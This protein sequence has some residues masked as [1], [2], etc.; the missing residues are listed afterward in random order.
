V[1]DLNERNAEKAKTVQELSGKIDQIVKRSKKTPP[2]NNNTVAKASLNPMQLLDKADRFITEKLINVRKL[3]DYAAKATSKGLQHSNT[4]LRN[5]TGILQNIV[6]GLAYSH[7]DLRNKLEFTGNRNYANIYAKGLANDLYDI[8]DSDPVSLARVHSVLD[9]EV[10]EHPVSYDELNEQ[11]KNL[12]DMIRATNDMVHTWHYSEGLISKETFEKHKG[13][14]VARLYEEIETMPPDVKAEF[15]KSRA[16]FNMFKQRKNPSEVDLQI[17]RDP[18]Y[19]TAKRVAQMMQNQ[20]IFEYADGLNDS[21]TVTVSDTAFPNSTQLGK[22]GDKPYYG[23]LTGKFVPNYVAQDFKGF[24]YANKYLNDLYSAFKGYDKN[25][26]RQMLKKSKTVYSP[27]VQLGN[28]LSNYSFAYW[29]GID[30]L[31]YSKNLVKARKEVKNTDGRY[32]LDL[33]ES[34]ILGTDLTVGDL[35]PVLQQGNPNQVLG[36][37]Q[38]KIKSIVGSTK[39][40]KVAEKFDEFASNLYSKTDD[41]A[42]MSAYISLR[43]DYGYSK[44]DAV[45]RIYEGFQNYATVGKAYDLA[46]R[47]PIIGNPYI[48]FKGDLMRILKNAVTRRPLTSITYLMTLRLVADLLSEASGEDEE[49]KKARERRPFIPKIKVPGFDPIPLVWQVPGIGEV[50]V[51]RFISPYSIYSKG[52]KSDILN[53]VTEWLPYQFELANIS[54]SKEINVTLPELSDVFLGVYA[55][56]ALDRDFRGLSIRDPKGN[57]FVT[58]ATPEEQIINS[59]R[60]MSRSQIPFYRSAEDLVNAINGEPDYYERER[61]VT[62]SI[63]NNII[64]VQEFGPEQVRDQLEKEIGYK[65]AKFESYHRDISMLRNVLKRDMRKIYEMNIDESKKQELYKTETDKFKKRVAEKLQEQVDIIKELEEPK[66]ILKN[67]E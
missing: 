9:P 62:Q 7:S 14:Y 21:K 4:V 40:G 6:G 54:K 31:T 46:A 41:L 27:L 8:V 19:A 58:V 26:A 28:F 48:R 39:L 52:D 53:E 38:N 35:Q 49:L 64:K 60:Y 20:A 51:A 11:E 3:E 2:S 47:T 67:L 15:N 56:M 12:Y 29:T 36:Q 50:N 30:P 42:K 18:V 37:T 23:S 44:E 10:A 55:Q 16:D 61:T 59:I 45:Q 43:D 13:K 33:I 63:L 17:L 66:N 25:I 32:Y 5:A 57:E 65:V 22:P 1:T 34:G 24:F